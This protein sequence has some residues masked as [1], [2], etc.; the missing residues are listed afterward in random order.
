LFDEEVPREGVVVER[1]AR[2]GRWI[3][4]SN[5]LWLANRKRVGRG[6]GSSGL[7]FDRLDD[8]EA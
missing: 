1:I 5:L 6:E 2:L 8:G 3:D 4:G 7:R